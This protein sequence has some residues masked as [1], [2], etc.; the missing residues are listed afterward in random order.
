MR[1]SASSPDSV[2]R[3]GAPAAEQTVQAVDRVTL[4]LY[5]GEV[6]GLV[7]ESGC[8]KTTLGRLVAGL[9]APSAGEIRFAAAPVRAGGGPPRRSR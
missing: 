9:D 4:D 3:P 5:A 7:G 1:S 8:G 2:P 6:L